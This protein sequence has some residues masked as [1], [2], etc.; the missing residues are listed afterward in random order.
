MMGRERASKGPCCFGDFDAEALQFLGSLLAHQVPGS[1]MRTD[2]RAKQTNRLTAPQGKERRHQNRTR[3]PPGGAARLS[4][5][6][7]RRGS[8][9]QLRLLEQCLRL[10]RRIPLCPR[11]GGVHWPGRLAHRIPN[12]RRPPRGGEVDLQ[13]FLRVG[14]GS[15]P[16]VAAEPPVS[17]HRGRST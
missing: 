3:L 4:D 7:K 6:Y 1:G 11:P 8:R 14:I 5:M 9:H 16:E 13:A 10:G 2:G 12:R 17:I 15:T